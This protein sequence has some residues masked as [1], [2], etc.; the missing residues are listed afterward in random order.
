[1]SINKFKNMWISNDA[2]TNDG[3]SLVNE[4]KS[5]F[6]NDVTATKYFM[7]NVSNS[8]VS[9]EYTNNQL[10]SKYYV[11]DSINGVLFNFYSVNTI[12]S[13]SSSPYALNT[14]SNYNL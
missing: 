7:P 12:S 5:K 11:D 4:G 2:T 13:T 1:M 14:F 9:E 8:I 3:Y 10:V 6:N